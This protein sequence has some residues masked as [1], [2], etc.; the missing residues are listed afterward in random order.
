MYWG[1]CVRAGFGS[2]VALAAGATG[3]AV[4]AGIG[5]AASSRTS[6]NNSRTAS[7]NTING[8]SGLLETNSLKSKKGDPYGFKYKYNRSAVYTVKKPN[9]GVIL[10]ASVVGFLVLL[11]I[12][13]AVISGFHS[14]KEFPNNPL[15]LKFIRLYVAILFAPIYLFYIFIRTTVFNL[16]LPF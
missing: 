16:K 8:K 13:A 3:V 4:G 10:G 15:W 2:G 11:W 7:V 14:W 5:A 12:V 6:S 9:K 1:P